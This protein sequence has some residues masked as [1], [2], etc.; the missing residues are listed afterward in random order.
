MG[1]V[2]KS[3]QSETTK[4]EQQSKLRIFLLGTF[5][6]LLDGVP[7]RS[8][9]SDKARGLLAYL[10]VE[11]KA[12]HR[13]EKLVGLLWPE[14]PEKRARASLSQALYNLR[15]SLGDQHAAE[16]FLEVT[17]STIRFNLNSDHWLDFAI[18]PDLFDEVEQHDHAS[19]EGCNLCLEKLEAAVALYR[20]E[21][22]AGFYLDG[23]QAFQE[24]CLLINERLHRQVIAAL[25]RLVD[26]Y[27]NRGQIDQAL[28]YA[29]WL[30]DLDPYAEAAQRQLMRLLHADGQLTTALAQYENHRRILLA[31]L[32]VEPSPETTALYEQI[33]AAQPEEVA[34]RKQCS[35]LPG[36]LT[37][38]IGREQEMAALDE[39][40]QDPDCRLITILG[41]GGI[42]KT[43]L[44]IEVARAQL[45]NFIHGVYLIPLNPVQSSEA[46][47]PN[48]AKVLE[49]PVQES[50]DILGPLVN[51]LRNKNLLL[52]M[53][54]FE[55]LVDGSNMLTEILRAAPGVKL[56]VTS[57]SCL[58]LKGENLYS[59]KG[60]KFPDSGILPSE[61][62]DY[63]GVQL[64]LACARR[65]RPDYVPAK[66]DLEAIVQVCRQVQGMPLGILLASAWMATMSAAEIAS[67]IEQGLAFLSTDW[68]DVPE[69]Q[70]SLRATF[71]YS[72]N[73]LSRRE[74]EIFQ[75]L[76]VFR[77]GL[78]R[79][80][81]KYICEALPNELR[82]L[83]GKSLLTCAP[84]GR[85]DIHELM[86]QFAAEKLAASP[87]DYDR[88]HN[89][90]SAYYCQQLL[91]WGQEMKE[92][93]QELA[94]SE[95]DIEHENARAACI[96]A[97][98]R[99][100]TD[101]LEIGLDGLCRY[102]ELRVRYLEGES[103]C[104]LVVEKLDKEPHSNEDQLLMVRL[105]FWSSRF[106]RLLERFEQAR[107]RLERGKAILEESEA[108]GFDVRWERAIML[109]EYGEMA[110]IHNPEIAQD[111]YQRSLVLFQELDGP[112]QTTMVQLAMGENAAIAMC[113]DI[114][115]ASSL[116][117]G[118]FDAF[119]GWGDIRGMARS[120]SSSS[121]IN[122]RIGF[123]NQALKQIDEAV[124]LYYSIGDQANV[125][126][127]L[128]GLGSIFQWTGR[129]SEASD[130]LL[131]CL[132]IYQELGDNYEIT[133][134]HFV[135]STSYLQSGDYESARFYA[136]RCLDL[137]QK[138][139]FQ[140]NVSTPH[141]TLSC[142]DI[143][144]QNYA[145]AKEHIEKCISSLRKLHNQVELSIGLFVLSHLEYYLGNTKQGWVC[146][147]KALQIGVD[148]HG[149]FMVFTAAFQ[150]SSFFL[151]VGEIER[152]VEFIALA[153]CH[154]AIANSRWV[155]DVYE[156]P[157][158]EAAKA[159]PS[160]VV[161]A[162]QE[163]GR[164]RDIWDTA[165]ELLTEFRPEPD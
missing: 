152:A 47:L 43:R 159:L 81:A 33:R 108:C 21:F 10:A 19:L 92:S 155:W 100:K 114:V 163:R 153:K 117:S 109:F 28:A 59:L 135:L 83:V 37:T 115:A 143:V 29:H 78:T 157:V 86:R 5:Y 137:A 122:V 102:Y 136:L 15:T 82:T 27:E 120:L 58:N 142:I 139:G 131:R 17:R 3:E 148:I 134:V 91:R 31:E 130:L 124:T 119:N 45:G 61:A 98:E 62:N 30:V 84:G 106:N 50:S 89:Q 145:I 93:K 32:G 26:A 35:N 64:F 151:D 121:M 4:Q 90:H 97:A 39:M 46:I 141:I 123:F 101:C 23:V 87:Q 149:I 88:S 44:V 51:Y 25:E 42:G 125:A 161:A 74:Q 38:F 41:P 56:L 95:V 75:S 138:Y 154:P 2:T 96:W 40:L 71:D 24:W 60:M 55:R 66:S 116:L 144:E 164:Q 111:F 63:D 77:G 107:I 140:L 110:V 6:V 11:N 76:S 34:S 65:V 147:C 7:I 126:A 128:S 158:V 146:F 53:D 165:K 1:A 52:V 85:Y 118:C 36:S 156:Q 16:P 9:E 113:G 73:L 49:L 54:G 12:P 8:F 94:L 133:H 69:R 67:E 79:A 70:C 14:M 20:G 105:L 103:A 129:F 57:R 13:R 150:I 127:S 162:A 112:W 72:W 132:P 99:C 48:V 80:A 160:E 18:F 22:L 104:Q 68:V